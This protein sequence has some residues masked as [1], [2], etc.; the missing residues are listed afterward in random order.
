MLPNNF[1]FRN[2]RQVRTGA[3]GS[4][5]GIIRIDFRKRR[6]FCTFNRK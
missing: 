1:I 6:V 3:A 2:L 4:E 5:N